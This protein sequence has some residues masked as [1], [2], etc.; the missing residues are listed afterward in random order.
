MKTKTHIQ[1]GTGEEAVIHVIDTCE[2]NNYLGLLADAGW[3]IEEAKLIE[4]K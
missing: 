4:V 2:V 1:F 3:N